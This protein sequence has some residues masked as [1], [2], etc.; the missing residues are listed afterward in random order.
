MAEGKGRWVY[1][2]AGGP[3]GMLELANAEWALDEG[4][5]ALRFADPPAG[6]RDVVRMGPIELNYL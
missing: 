2:H 5:P 3:F 4:R 6:R 1:D